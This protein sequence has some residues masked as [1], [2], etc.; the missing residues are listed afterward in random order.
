M[1]SEKSL[2]FS[3]LTLCIPRKVGIGCMSEEKKIQPNI[4]KQLKGRHRKN[5]W[6]MIVTFLAAIVVFCTTY[7]MILPAI[8]MEKEVNDEEQA[9]EC[10]LNVEGSDY[11]VAVHCGLDAGFRAD[12]QLIV[13]ELDTGSGAY[14]FYVEQAEKLLGKTEEEEVLLA[15][16]YEIAFEYQG[17]TLKADAPVT[18]TITYDHY[19]R[20]AS[21]VQEY[22]ITDNQGQLEKLDAEV[23]ENADGSVSFTIKQF[24]GVL[25]GTVAYGQKGEQPVEEEEE[26][27]EEE[28]EEMLEVQSEPVEDEEKSVQEDN[29]IST[30]EEL[31]K[32]ENGGTYKLTEDVTVTD[33]T[34]EGLIKIKGGKTTTLNLNGHKIIYNPEKSNTI[35][36]QYLLAIYDTSQLIL[37]DE[38]QASET[39]EVIT[40]KAKY[41]NVA[42]YDAATET[43]TYYV[44]ESAVNADGI[45]TTETL[46]KH[47]ADLKNV[48]AIESTGT[49]HPSELI[50][51]QGSEAKL[52]ISGGRYTNPAGNHAIYV[53][54]TGSQVSISGGYFCG[55]YSKDFGG[56]LYSRG[57]TRISG[58][59][60]AANA[61]FSGGAIYCSGAGSISGT[62]TFSMSGGIV[63]GNTLTTLNDGDNG[64]GAGI[65]LYHMTNSNFTGGYVTNNRSD[66]FCGTYGEGAHHGGGIYQ[67]E[68]AMTLQGDIKVTG[69][70]HQEAGGGIAF[71][72]TK[73]ILDGGIIAAN[74]A[75]TGEGGGIRLNAS[76]QLSMFKSGYIT[77]NRTNTVYDWGGGGVFVVT[78][79][80]MQM[81]NALITQ[82][83]ADGFG[84][85]VG[86][87]STGQLILDSSSGGIG[88]Y[89][90]TA[91]GREMAGE[92]ELAN[93]KQQDLQAQANEV[94]MTN[95][96]ADFFCAMNSVVSGNML[97]DGVE[98]YHGS[99]DYVEADIGK[100]ESKAANKMMGLTA[101]PSEEDIA[102]AK[103]AATLFITGNFSGTHGG[104]ITSNGMAI[105]GEGKDVILKPGLEVHTEK[106]CV[107]ENGAKV[108]VTAGQFQFLLLDEQKN[109]ITRV[110]NDAKGNIILEPDVPEQEGTIVYYLKEEPG[111]D[112]SISY[113]TTEYKLNVHVK[114]V[115]KQL[116]VGEYKTLALTYYV[117]DQV[118]V[119]V[120]GTEES[121]WGY[122]AEELS[123][124][125]L[126]HRAAVTITRGNGAAGFTNKIK[127]KPLYLEITKTDGTTGNAMRFIEFTLKDESGEVI[128]EK[129]TGSNGIV[130]FQVEA[131]KT[132]QIHEKVPDGYMYAGPWRL[133]IDENGNAKIYEGLETEKESLNLTCET[134]DSAIYIR[135]ALKN[136]AGGYELPDTGGN[137]T[138]PYRAAGLLLIFLAGCCAKKKFQIKKLN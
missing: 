85:G 44:T 86:G 111:K 5:R 15:R 133:V 78:G 119:T 83:H 84:G 120:V 93:S 103:A 32:L 132:Y 66:Y 56:A 20:N 46:V 101:S 42:E 28:T 16:F 124:Y 51:L 114:K 123:D 9:Q 37:T 38:N 113:D 92:G 48:G 96:Y 82:N 135:W 59:V 35:G 137:G 128:K 57:V 18:V 117:V 87:C 76:S 112:S 24:E 116:Q 90:N 126:Y 81:E 3:F 80:T 4:E 54:E 70:Y 41:G 107:D 69:N 105:L 22:V 60:F 14:T 31:Y 49:N 64:R 94:F 71:H 88:L 43:L 30:A 91:D 72:G 13:K 68:G 89:G 109:V 19:Q 27:A 6:H 52:D 63:S 33:S 2:P 8:S 12:T 50:S 130:S 102:K 47:V 29:E 17:E 125:H 98:N 127:E 58:G 21:D 61:G 10:D 1:G 122:Q 23:A 121:Y 55:T 25:V 106:A 73:M 138:F 104:G 97:G 34:V 100:N 131:G 26:I 67:L 77:N 45:T 115:E 129:K 40:S 110:Q 65:S 39:T 134:T 118:K 74:V 36:Y 75:Q 136:Y 7:A 79:Y 53:K 11:R 62:C 99:I 95:G 108:D